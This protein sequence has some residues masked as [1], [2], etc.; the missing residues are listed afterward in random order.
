MIVIEQNVPLPGKDGLHPN[1]KYPFRAMNVGE[2]FLVA[3]RSANTMRVISRHHAMKT[4]YEFKVRKAGDG[5]RIWR[6]A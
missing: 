6:T 1:T 3:D 4:G 5:A 2:S